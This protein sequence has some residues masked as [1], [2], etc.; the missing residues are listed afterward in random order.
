MEPCHAPQATLTDLLE[1]VLDKGIMLKLDLVIGVAGIP[2]IGI[3]LQGAIAAIETM[4]GYGMMAGWDADTR[5]DAIRE[6][7]HHR[8]GLRPGEHVTLEQY[9]SYRHARGIVRIWRPGRLILTEQR[10][11]LIRP[12]PTEVLFETPVS[13]IAGIG[14][15][16][17]GN[18][19]GGGREVVC[20]ALADGRL[21]ALYTP[22][23][24]QL[25]AS[26]RARLHRLGQPITEISRWDIKQL[27]PGAVAQGQLWHRWPPG[28]AT[29]RWR[30]GWT[31]LTPT[32]LTW[33]P[34]RPEHALLRVPLRD[35][36]ALAVE[37]RELGILGE[38]EVL[39]VTHQ[40]GGGHA[41]ALFAGDGIGSWSAVVQRVADTPD[42]HGDA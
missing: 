20:L 39:V 14:R 27:D 4:L 16:F 35:I 40:T 9:G 28:Q 12:V 25:E 11:L 33:R 22:E 13:A 2:L 10:L 17:E 37:R 19:G 21:E 24:D 31:V 18:A 41:E 29:Q 5:A 6:A 15:V 26:L 36:S 38:R 7:E 3:S 34:D 32:E 1:R 30:S 42:W 8:F 23:P